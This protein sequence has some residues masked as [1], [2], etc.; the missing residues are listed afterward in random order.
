M[1]YQANNPAGTGI[2][3]NSESNGTLVYGNTT[4]GVPENGF[5]IFNSSNSWFWGNVTSAN[6]HGGI[7]IYGP[8]DPGTVSYSPGPPPANNFVQGNYAFN[9]PFNAGVNLNNSSTTTV[10]NNMVK[11]AP[12]GIWMQQ[13]SGD[14]VFLNL[15]HNDGQGV[16]A[17]AAR[18]ARRIS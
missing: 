4:S 12:A 17:F 2:W 5:T 7:F 18:R 14:R 15:L 8:T 6:G 16:H 13:T 1:Q 11:S 9:L 3:L 10:F